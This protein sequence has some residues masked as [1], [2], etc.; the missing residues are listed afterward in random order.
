MGEDEIKTNGYIDLEYEKEQD[1]IKVK[2]MYEQDVNESAYVYS[3]NPI[4]SFTGNSD[5]INLYNKERLNNENSLGNNSCI[6]IE[7]DIELKA[8]EEK[9]IAFVFGTTKENIETKYM[10]STEAE[11]VKLFANTYLALRVSYFKPPLLTL[12]H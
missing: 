11:A 10:N 6:A 4:K 7:V 2:N 5:S 3:S 12:V 8:F 9:E 1:Y